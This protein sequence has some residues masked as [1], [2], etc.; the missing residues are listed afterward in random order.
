[1]IKGM[2]SRLNTSQSKDIIAFRN[3]KIKLRISEIVRNM[4]YKILYV[5]GKCVFVFSSE[6]DVMIKVVMFD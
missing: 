6:N 2:M 3:F 4:V 5:L 1:M